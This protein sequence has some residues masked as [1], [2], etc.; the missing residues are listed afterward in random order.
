MLS[1]SFHFLIFQP[2]HLDL[3]IDQNIKSIRIELIQI[4]SKAN[5]VKSLKLIV[6]LDPKAMFGFVRDITMC[7]DTESIQLLFNFFPGRTPTANFSIKI[8][9]KAELKA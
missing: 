5:F 2:F 4:I 1:S 6:V 8:G 7:R 3:D 9:Y